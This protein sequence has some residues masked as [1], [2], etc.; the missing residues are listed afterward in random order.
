MVLKSRKGKRII[1]FTLLMLFAL[2]LSVAY[3]IADPP[4]LSV[5]DE[6]FPAFQ[7]NGWSYGN[8]F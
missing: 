3:V 1:A 7:S 2:D 8:N 4:E 6:R 5:R